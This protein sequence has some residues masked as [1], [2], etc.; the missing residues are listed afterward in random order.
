V[1]HG[2]TELVKRLT[3]WDTDRLKEEKERGISIELGFAPLRLDPETL[4]GIVDVPG[5]EKFVK[6]MVAGAG[7]IDLAMLLVAADE[8]VMPQTREHLEVLR[9]LR[10]AS[11]VV[12]ISKGDLATDELL[13]MVRNDV[14][15]LVEGTFLQGAPVVVAS[16]KTG[17][18]I[19]DLKRIILELTRDIGERDRTGP[20][21]LAVDRVFHMQGIGVVVT[22]SGSSGTVGV[23]DSLEILPRGK[24]ARVREIQSFG[25]KREK[26][27]AGER[28]AIAL[29]GIKLDEI[30]RGDML[31]TTSAYSASSHIDARLRVADYAELELKHRERVRVHHFAREVLGRVL[32]LD[33]DLIRSGEDGLVQ[34]ALEEPIVASEG[35]YFVVRKYS[36]TRVLG[37]GRVLVARAARHRRRDPAV[38]R[39]LELQETGDAAE[40]LL[41]AVETAGL[42]GVRETALD[43]ETARALLRKGQI[44]VI[45][46][47]VFSR[48]V[49]AA[50]AAT[51]ERL[52]DEY[53]KSHPLR[54]GMDKEEL[55]QRLRFPHPTALFNRFLEAVAGCAPLFVRENR[56]RTRSDGLSLPPDLRREMDRL[57]A[58]LRDAGVFFL[59][60]P[61]I[62]MAWTGRSGVRDALEYLREQGI[63]VRLGDDGYMHAGAVEGC[64]QVLREWFQSHGELSVGDLKE[65]LGVTRKHAVPL[66]EHLDRVKMTVREENVRRRGPALESG[67]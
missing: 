3:G 20:F 44:A 7:G 23:G 47:L 55:R 5:H 60:V 57:E 58:V 16:A 15:E 18:G 49:L 34:L 37:G 40:K 35:D 42:N 24:K 21:R 66:L 52:A 32:L 62:E 22:G 53:V 59:R 65:L 46:G 9:S 64:R 26:G 14:N 11:G 27:Y 51:I 39:D 1:D 30:A 36:P 67:G 61:E 41:K 56:V 13:G 25:E 29:Q 43:T 2:K 54:Y 6:Q 48:R 4:V 19:E 10:V 38:I 12:V 17:D 28:L 45:D 8:G 31:V 33:A 63:A 50:T